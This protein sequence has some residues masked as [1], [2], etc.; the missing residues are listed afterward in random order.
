[1]SLEALLAELR[2]I[3][4]DERGLLAQL[5]QTERYAP[6]SLAPVGAI[7]APAEASIVTLLA[8]GHGFTAPAPSPVVN[9]DDTGVFLMGLQ[10][11][12]LTTQG[13]G[14]SQTARKTGLTSFDMTGKMFRVTFM[15]DQPTHLANLR[16]DCSN[17]SF[18][19]WWRGLFIASNATIVADP[20]LAAGTWYQMTIP[21]GLFTVGGGAPTR[22]GITAVQMVVV[23]DGTGVPVNV[24]LDKVALVPEPASALITLTFDDGRDGAFLKAKPILDAAGWRATWGPIVDKI[25]V[26]GYMTLTQNRALLEAGWDPAV[27]AYA[28]AI[29]NSYPTVSDSDAIRDTLLAKVWMRENGFG[30]A[31]NFLIPKGGLVSA[32]RDTAFRGSFALTRGTFPTVR[33][34]YPPGR[35][36]N[37]RPYNP[38]TKS[39]ATVEGIIDEAVN[40]KEWLILQLHQV[41]DALDGDAN[42]VLTADFQTLVTYIQGKGA[43]V[44]VKSLAEVIATGVS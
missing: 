12:R 33:E 29:H 25:G 42:T 2:L 35:P 39:V 10:S 32:A 18:T 23:D 5:H 26:T 8:S 3:L 17:D 38:G 1:M 31:D 41:A 44:K 19:N 40:N 14:V 7:I 30:P 36:W 16:F 4:P 27:H 6:V 11:L 24:W 28:S 21:W 22:T 34:T 20:L 43:A 15:V 37:L 13:A 9:V